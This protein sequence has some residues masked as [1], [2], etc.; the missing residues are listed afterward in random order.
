MGLARLILTAVI[1]WAAVLDPAALVGDLSSS[2]E[3]IRDEAAGALEELGRLALPARYRARG[4]DDLAFRRRVE[5]L[6]DLIERQRLLRATKVRLD[7][8]DRP[9]SAVAEDLRGQAGFPVLV[10]SD[11]VLRTKRVTLHAPG[12]VPFWEAIDRLGAASGVRHNPGIPFTPAP[13]EP[14]VLLGQA[15]GPPVPASDAGPFRVYFVHLGRQRVVTPARPPAEA[16]IRESLTADLIV[17]AEPGLAINPT[18]RAIME[19]V[20]D[21]SGRDLR[22]EIPVG[23]APRRRWP[24][25]FEEGHAGLLSLSLPL[26][27][28][29]VSGGRL[30]R[31]KGYV[32]IS[33]IAR[34]GDPAILPLAGDERKELHRGGVALSATG[35]GQ[36]GEGLSFALTIRDEQAVPRFAAGLATPGA[37]RPPYRVE[38]HV[39]VQDD[40]GRALWW[41]A[42]PVRTSGDGALEVQIKLSKGRGGVPT[43]LLYHGVIGD[44]TE[45]AFEFNDLPVP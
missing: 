19:E 7:Y 16:K 15:D 3:S 34:A 24:P 36:A 14:T 43:R 23:P 30:R 9:L 5:Q 26:K 32:P 22:P 10:G 1:G 28:A 33:V 37:Y 27:P 18:G 40:Q 29:A 12:P 6:I 13:R 21:E 4:S 2:R 41:N 20:V 45:V 17:V 31:L 25:R 42:V 39:Q 8:E 44:T 11:D 38:D 35:V